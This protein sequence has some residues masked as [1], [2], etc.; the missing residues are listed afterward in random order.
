MSYHQADA[1]NRIIEGR[2][3]STVRTMV[4]QDC[5]IFNTH[6]TAIAFNA[7]NKAGAMVV[8]NFL[9]SP[10]AQY[11]KNEPKNWGDFT[12][13]DIKR[14]T[15]EWQDNFHKLD[16]G[17][18]TLPLEILAKNGVPEIPSAYVEKLEDGWSRE[19]LGK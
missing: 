7:Q 3:P 8:A 4:M 9:M 11:S 15:S 18:A 2:Y 6:F 12:V 10:E 16:L 1:Q 19:V 13:L 5:S 14:L 17:D